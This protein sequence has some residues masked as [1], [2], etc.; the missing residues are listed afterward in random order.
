MTLKTSY[1]Q[2]VSYLQ[3]PK[4]VLLFS[5]FIITS[6]ISGIV[7]LVPPPETK[8]NVVPPPEK[9]KVDLALMKL[10][11]GMDSIAYSELKQASADELIPIIRA[12][13][14]PETPACQFQSCVRQKQLD[15]LES[16]DALTHYPDSVFN[17]YYF[18]LYNDRNRPEL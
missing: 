12:P 14:D 7:Y 3:N 15:F 5:P 10:Q 9:P 2:A 11:Y 8:D 16:R 13:N 17:A 4:H 1:Q 18:S 6:L